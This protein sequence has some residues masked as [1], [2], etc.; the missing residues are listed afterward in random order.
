MAYYKFITL[1]HRKHA[2]NPFLT[3][4]W[5]HSELAFIVYYRLTKQ[6]PAKAVIKVKILFL[7]RVV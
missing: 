2:A 5:E 1:L 3:H 7:P 4:Y 6:S